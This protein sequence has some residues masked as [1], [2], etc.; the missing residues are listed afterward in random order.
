MPS[1]G[2]RTRRSVAQRKP[3]ALSRTPAVLYPELRKSSEARRIDGIGDAAV[4]K[5][6]NTMGLF[7]SG[8]LETC[9]DKGYIAVSV[10]GKGDEPKLRTAAESILR[11]VL[12]AL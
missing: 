8:E 1:F 11:K 12:G 10:D 3:R 7:N 2:A 4:W 5:F 9:G 6:S